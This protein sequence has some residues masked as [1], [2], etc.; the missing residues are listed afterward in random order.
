MHETGPSGPVHWDDP[1]GWDGEW[2][3]RGGSGWETHTHPWLNRIDVWQKP[4]QYC[5]VISLQL[6]KIN[7]GGAEKRNRAIYFF[8][9]LNI[10]WPNLFIFLLYGHVAYAILLPWPMDPCTL[11]WKHGVLITRPP[12]K[13]QSY[14]LLCWVGWR[15]DMHGGMWQVK[16]CEEGYKTAGN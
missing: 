7:G 6:I 15:M 10:S 2:G 9:F 1:E 8:V 16:V 5:K 13:S 14:V 4:L 11:Q 3:G 12:G